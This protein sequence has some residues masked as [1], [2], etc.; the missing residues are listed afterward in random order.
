M[1]KLSKQS[2]AMLGFSHEESYSLAAIVN[3]LPTGYEIPK[4]ITEDFKGIFVVTRKID[5]KG[6]CME[7]PV[8]VFESED[9]VKEVLQN[10]GE[11]LTT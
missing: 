11:C 2:A 5:Y 9:L 7:R 4:S 1:F 10:V 6:Y 8:L 3:R